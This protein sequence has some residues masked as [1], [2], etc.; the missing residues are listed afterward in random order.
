MADRTD[1]GRGVRLGAAVGVRVVVGGPVL[2]IARVGRVLDRF[3]R[4]GSAA[5]DRE[6]RGAAGDFVGLRLARGVVD[7]VVAQAQCVLVDRVVLVRVLAGRG[8]EP[9][10]VVVSVGLA[11]RTADVPA[12]RRVVRQ[13]GD[14]AD[15]V[16]RVAQVLERG[17]AR[18][19]GLQC[20]E[21]AVLGVVGVGGADPVAGLLQ[22]LLP[23]FVV[24]DP[25]QV[26]VAGAVLGSGGPADLAARVV[27]VG[28]DLA[29]GIG[30]LQHTVEGVVAPGGGVGA[31]GVADRGDGAGLLDHLAQRPVGALHCSRRVVDLG[32][33]RCR[34]VRCAGGAVLVGDVAV[35]ERRVADGPQPRVLVVVLDGLVRCPQVR[36]DLRCD[37]PGE[38]VA[39][40]G[41]PGVRAVERGTASQ[42][43]VADARDVVLVVGDRR[44]LTCGVVRVAGPDLR[45]AVEFLHRGGG[46]P[47]VG[48]GAAL[49]AV[50]V[51]R[52]P[53]EAGRARPVLAEAVS[54]AGG[55]AVR[56][57]GP[58]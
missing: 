32:D 23:E 55:D 25:V 46:A 18:R 36:G 57:H 41:A 4:P 44:D 1:L 37:V 15:L 28:Q 39:G 16:V 30:H 22:D 56:L 21:S 40:L 58:D 8:G 6:G 5:S 47:D 52:R 13:R 48:V 29:V 19:H 42:C 50:A 27:V 33:A 45:G 49:L 12:L 38:V 14:V 2:D 9:V 10:L 51:G 34:V 3:D 26:R 31:R 54:G 7:R 20:S 53:L 35:R 11:A 24:V 17:S 43:V